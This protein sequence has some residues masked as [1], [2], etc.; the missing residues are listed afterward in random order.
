M[1]G[2]TVPGLTVQTGAAP[3]AV[4]FVG[5]GLNVPGRT[6]GTLAPAAPGCPSITLTGTETPDVLRAPAWEIELA[7]IATM[8]NSIGLGTV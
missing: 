4:V 2:V 8:S 3:G 6:A 7:G 1:P 5:L